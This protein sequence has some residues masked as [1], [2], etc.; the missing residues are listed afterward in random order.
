[1]SLLADVEE[2]RLNE[3]TVHFEMVRTA[4]SKHLAILK[5]VL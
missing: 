2:L 5:E 3:L 1:M 4:V